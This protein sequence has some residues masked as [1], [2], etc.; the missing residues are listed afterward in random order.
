MNG[1]RWLGERPGCESGMILSDRDGKRRG[2]E[3][4]GRERKE[5]AQLGVELTLIF[6][7]NPECHTLRNPENHKF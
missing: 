2:K 1:R 3:E 7:D 5:E 6:K 4:E